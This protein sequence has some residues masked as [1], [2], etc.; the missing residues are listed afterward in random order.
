[1]IG[2]AGSCALRGHSGE[3][4][5]VPASPP[6]Y[7][8]QVRPVPVAQARGVLPVERTSLG[9]RHSGCLQAPHVQGRG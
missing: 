2:F 4:Y 1:M 8:Y 6:R 3:A 7:R 5:E 9:G